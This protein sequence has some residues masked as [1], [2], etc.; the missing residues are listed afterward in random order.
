MIKVENIEV[1]NFEGAF[2]GLRNP[3]N[4]WAKGDSNYTNDI[5]WTEENKAKYNYREAFSSD[6]AIGPNDMKLAQRMI[7]GGAEEAKF[8]R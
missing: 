4:S 7:G 5:V 6:Y 2:R 8:L 1:F 3:M